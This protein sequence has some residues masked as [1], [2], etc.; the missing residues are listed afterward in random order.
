MPKTDFPAHCGTRLGRLMWVVTA[1]RNSSFNTHLTSSDSGLSCP[2]KPG[3]PFWHRSRQQNSSLPN[4]ASAWPPKPLREEGYLFLLPS[5]RPWNC[6]LGQGSF[7][8]YEVN[9]LEP[10][11]KQKCFSFTLKSQCLVLNTKQRMSLDSS[12]GQSLFF[13]KPLISLYF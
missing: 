3:R 4:F 9:N 12:L 13:I 8:K 7:L 6:S 11:F 2:F 1:L 5:H 10:G